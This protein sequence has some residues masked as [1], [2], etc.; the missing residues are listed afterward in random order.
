MLFS[1]RN[2]E[3]NNCPGHRNQNNF[4][5][6]QIRS[7]KCTNPIP[8]TL[9]SYVTLSRRPAIFLPLPRTQRTG[10]RG[11][12]RKN[13]PLPFSFW[14]GGIC[15]TTNQPRAGK[16]WTE[17]RKREEIRFSMKW[18]WQTAKPSSPTSRGEGISSLPSPSIR[19]SLRRKRKGRSTSQSQR[20]SRNISL[21]LRGI[22]HASPS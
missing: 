5:F 8:F 17:R 2:A 22:S 18:E 7:S 14:A 19:Y 13:V 6:R 9:C 10:R 20:E 3:A 16:G 15:S 11:P 12:K 21:L 4:H 1:N